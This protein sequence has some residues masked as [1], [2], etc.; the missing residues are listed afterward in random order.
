M[1]FDIEVSPVYAQ[2]P[3]RASFTSAGAV[4]LCAKSDGWA[5]T[6]QRKLEI[7]YDG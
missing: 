5:E 4:W 3:T 6:F 7:C 2:H 1:V